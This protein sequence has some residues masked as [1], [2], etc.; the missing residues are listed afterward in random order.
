MVELPINDDNNN[1]QRWISSILVG[2]W[3]NVKMASKYLKKMTKSMVL[4]KSIAE[5]KWQ[6]EIALI[7]RNWASELPKKSNRLFLAQLHTAKSTC[8]Y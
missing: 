8:L 1:S 2:M 6:F 5:Q 7:R 4:L 3:N